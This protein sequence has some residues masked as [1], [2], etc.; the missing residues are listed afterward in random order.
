MTTSISQA[1]GIDAGALD[2]LLGDGI[3][4]RAIPPAAPIGATVAVPVVASVVSPAA[5]AELSTASALDICA[6]AVDAARRV[7]SNPNDAI[8]ARHFALSAC[9]AAP[10]LAADLASLASAGLVARLLMP[11]LHLNVAASLGRAAPVALLPLVAAYWMAGLYSEV[12]I[13]PALELR[14]LVRTTTLAL[15][16]AAIASFSAPELAMWCLS[17][18][19]AAIVFTP[20]ARALARRCCAGL[21][22]WGFPTLVIGSG[23]GADRTARMLM[24][25]RCGL[26]PVLV[27]DPDGDRRASIVPVMN[28]PALLR[29]I[30]RSKGVRHAVMSTDD[31]PAVKVARAFDE[32]G[33]LA[34]H[35]LVVCDTP[36]LPALWGAQ[37]F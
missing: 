6:G 24:R 9:T 21:S 17:G 13:H 14:Q 26:R 18:W 11:L 8:L 36:P 7:D 15:F 32:Y 28:D 37:R 2:D 30:V 22:W 10:L 25:S 3:R 35:L 33:D 19:A 20:L 1:T 31:F 23:G 12:W 5:K 4:T 29:S 16:A 27:T 34:S